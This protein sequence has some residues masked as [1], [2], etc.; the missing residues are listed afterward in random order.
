[1]HHIL[2]TVLQKSSLLENH[3]SEHCLAQVCL[4]FQK[5]LRFPLG[6][7]L[8]PPSDAALF[9]FVVVNKLYIYIC[10]LSSFALLSSQHKQPS[11]RG[12]SAVPNSASFQ[13]W[14]Y[15]LLGFPFRR[16]CKVMHHLLVRKTKIYLGVSNSLLLYIGGARSALY[17]CCWMLFNRAAA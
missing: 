6:V 4:L 17:E 9:V 3:Y 11:G 5:L 8:V 1:M 13:S 14:S 7:D 10:C 12:Q 2:F 16:E 15:M